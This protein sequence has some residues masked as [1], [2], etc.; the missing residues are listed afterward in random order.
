[1]GS[2]RRPSVVS[3]PSG[4]HRLRDAALGRHLHVALQHHPV[5][6]I[7]RVA[8]HEIRAHGADQSLQ[9]PDARPLADGVA[10]RHPLGGEERD[11]HVVHVAAVVHDEDDR[12]ARVD[13][14]QRRRVGVAE[15]DAVGHLGE[16]LGEPVADPEVDV[17]V[18]RRHDLA[19]VAVHALDEHVA[20]HAALGDLLLHRR[21]HALI[22]RQAVEQGAPPGQLELRQLD[23]EARADLV[24]DAAHLAPEVPAHAGQ[25]EPLERR[26]QRQADE[27]DQS[28]SGTATSCVTAPPFAADR[29]RRCSRRAPCA[30]TC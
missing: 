24:H 21:E 27:H 1:M 20:R 8:A 12:R 22:A 18:E 23:L 16:R 17:G 4:V 9:R 3:P 7:A 6:R 13:R 5:E 28:Q 15:A 10:Q 25:Q 11:Q 14:R 2:R 26:E 19:G 30:G 29:R